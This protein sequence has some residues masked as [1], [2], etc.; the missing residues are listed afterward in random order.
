MDTELGSQPSVEEPFYFRQKTFTSSSL[1]T[2][3]L[4]PNLIEHMGRSSKG[5]RRHRNE[6]VG[7]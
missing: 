6:S 1:Y 3:L 2:Q 5:L 4:T 7:S